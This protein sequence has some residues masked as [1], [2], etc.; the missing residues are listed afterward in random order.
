MKPML[1]IIH[2]RQAYV[3]RLS[4][5]CHC[6]DGSQIITTPV[7]NICGNVPAHGMLPDIA[8]IRND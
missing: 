6:F 7:K 5:N 2:N 1:T 4:K 8:K 3:M